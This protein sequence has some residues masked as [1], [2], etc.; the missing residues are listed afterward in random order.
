[1]IKKMKEKRKEIIINDKKQ[2]NVD[3]TI[4]MHCVKTSGLTQGVDAF[5]RRSVVW[6]LPD[7]QS[8]YTI[9]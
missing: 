9:E 8:L 3:S 1:M 4:R 5:Q 2:P 6:F 7:M